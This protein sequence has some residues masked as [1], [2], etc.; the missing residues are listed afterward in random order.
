MQTINPNPD[1]TVPYLPCKPKTTTMVAKTSISPNLL[2]D[3]N[4]RNGAKGAK[5]P[6]P[7]QAQCQRGEST[8][9]PFSALSRVDSFASTLSSSPPVAV[10]P[11]P[12]ASRVRSRLLSRLGFSPPPL[13]PTDNRRLRTKSCS[14]PPSEPQDQDTSFQVALN[15]ESESSSQIL[16]F[17]QQSSSMS[18]MDS[19]SLDGKEKAVSFASS[20]TVHPIPKHSAYSNRIRETI[21]PNPIEMQESAARNCIEF[22][23]EGW[24]WR[25]VAEE[26]DMVYYHGEMVHPIHFAHECNIRQQ[27]CAVMSAQNQCLSR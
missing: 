19:K 15:D 11:A 5:D 25:H 3:E 8:T 10:A 12:S 22:A 17:F 16:P 27:F 4:R 2:L 26:E 1:T 13:S 9:E 6:E 14:Q 20:V 18:S 21:W 7:R 24:N 23:S